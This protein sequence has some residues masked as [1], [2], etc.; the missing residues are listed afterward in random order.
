MSARYFYLFVITLTFSSFVFAQDTV[1]RIAGIPVNEL[2]RGNIPL[3]SDFPVTSVKYFNVITE[4]LTHVTIN[5][6]DENQVMHWKVVITEN[7]STKT[8]E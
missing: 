3:P 5:L 1:D 8:V 2:Y 6:L 7:A 4:S